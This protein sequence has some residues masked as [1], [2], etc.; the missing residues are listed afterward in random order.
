MLRLDDG[1]LILAATD[2]TNHLACAHL[3]QQRL[4][5]ARGERGKPRPVDDP[6]ADLIRD[7]GEA[8]ERE[9][10]DRLSAEC[11]GH[12]DVSSPISPY[13]REA[14]HAA[15]ARTTQAMRDGVP[16]IF[17]AQFFD[18]RWQGRADFLRR[19]PLPSD[20]GDH[21]Y[22][23][24]DTKLARQVKPHV[25]HQLSLYSRLVA[26]V[27][28]RHHPFAYLILGDGCTEQVAFGRYAA[29]HRHV[30][31]QMEAVVVG[32]PLPT[33]PEPVAHCAICA[34]SLECET[35][36]RADDHLSLVAFARRDQ[37]EK[38]VD[39]QLGTVADLA[40]APVELDPGPLG[41]NAYDVLR[42]QAALQVEA[43]ETRRPT[44]R[45]VTPVAGMG[46]ARL[47]HPSAGDVFFDLEGDPYVGTDGG[48][49]YLW[50]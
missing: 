29:L 13:T 6:H 1:T 36:R 10:L 17:Q 28:G 39:L 43:R 8:H 49:E 32:D 37:R 23:V 20:L 16:L 35:R 34:L 47:P 11:G 9:Q 45:H 14:L 42:H 27:Q 4:A 25:I 48:I 5:I 24:L 3:T 41:H 22:E 21:S 50:G 40:A 46:Y 38:L 44:R 18:G 30:V 31:R 2:L 33:Y 15:A 19:V 26:E 7:R 12:V